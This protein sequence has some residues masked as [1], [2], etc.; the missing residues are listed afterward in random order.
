MINFLEGMLAAPLWVQI[1]GAWL[2]VV[3]TAA[4]VFL[5]QREGRIVLAVWALNGA[6]MMLMAQFHGY[7]RL[8]GL[9]HVV[10][11]T[12]LLLLLLRSRKEFSVADRYGRWL[13]V[14]M[15]TIA[16]SLVFDYVDVVRYVLGDRG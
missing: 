5:K 4:V 6:T 10:W 16:I 8:L 11:W 12:P 7:T 1:W 9:V 14:L 3:N 13:Y 15:V 2:V